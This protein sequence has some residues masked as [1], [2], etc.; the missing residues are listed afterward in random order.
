[1]LLQATSST[2]SLEQSS[3]RARESVGLSVWSPP[4]ADEWS[5]D[6][7]PDEIHGRSLVVSDLLT[8]R[9]LGDVKVEVSVKEETASIGITDGDGQIPLDVRET[10][11]LARDEYELFGTMPDSMGATRASLSIVSEPDARALTVVAAV[12]SAVDLQVKTDHALPDEVHV[13]LIAVPP[14]WSTPNGWFLPEEEVYLQQMRLADPDNYRRFI[15]RRRETMPEVPGSVSLGF[16]L[17]IEQSIALRVG[18]THRVAVPY[19][20][21]VFIAAH[22][23]TMELIPCTSIV[24]LERGVVRDGELVLEPSP[25]ISGHVRMPS[26]DP[27]AGFPVV[28]SCRSRFY[29]NELVPRA[30]NQPA[31]PGFVVETT[32]EGDST[33]FA[34]SRATTDSQGYFR[35]FVPFTDSVS[36]SCLVDGFEKAE[37]R[38]VGLQRNESVYGLSI[39][40]SE[41]EGAKW[42]RFIESD[43]TAARNFRFTPAEVDPPHP[44]KLQYPELVT[45]EDGVVSVAFLD[46]ERE[47]LFFPEGGRYR[48]ASFVCRYGGTVVCEEVE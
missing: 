11:L 40:L 9:P 46:S 39:K 33:V 45:D 3:A 1:M 18:E 28:V 31:N 34:I 6:T 21:D 37:E 24:S 48:Q 32:P 47:Y 27:A 5:P 43:G 30:A 15:Q 36:V 2:G 13:R 20:G 8:G 14:L 42:M 19:E 16:A 7:E 44:F 22:A 10:M 26:G 12:Y 17:S 35:L 23:D 25:A 29:E 38:V 41:V 4:N